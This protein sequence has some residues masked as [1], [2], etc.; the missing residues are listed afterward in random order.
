MLRLEQQR[1]RDLAKHLVIQE[2][3]LGAVC[4]DGDK[5][6]FY[7]KERVF[8][9]ILEVFI[10]SS[11]RKGCHVVSTRYETPHIYGLS[12]MPCHYDATLTMGLLE[13][14]CS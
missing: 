11:H 5:E 1:T 8:T 10:R 12:C 6:Q 2:K 14:S 4:Y 13:T 9:D 7:T 3:H